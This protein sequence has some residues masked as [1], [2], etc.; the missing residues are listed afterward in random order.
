MAQ[1]VLAILVDAVLL[2]LEE[3]PEDSL[4]VVAH[5]VDV[6]LANVTA[7][8]QDELE[9]AGKSASVC[10]ASKVITLT[11]STLFLTT[12]ATAVDV[13]LL[14]LARRVVIN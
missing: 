5:L 13:V 14:L 8:K 6:L 2:S 12:D 9:S 4:V 7:V 3:Q 1:T 11:I 10:L